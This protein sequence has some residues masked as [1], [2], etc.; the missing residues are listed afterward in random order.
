MIIMFD[1]IWIPGNHLSMLVNVTRLYLFQLCYISFEE[2]AFFKRL[3]QFKCQSILFCA[4]TNK[5]WKRSTYTLNV[6][7]L[8]IFTRWIFYRLI[9]NQKAAQEY[10]NYCN[11]NEYN[12]VWTYVLGDKSFVVCIRILFTIIRIIEECAI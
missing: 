10:S 8:S 11:V 2:T 7:V 12:L 5:R 6:L 3:C 9:A 4:L 1:I